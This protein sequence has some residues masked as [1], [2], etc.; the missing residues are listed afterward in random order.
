MSKVNNEVNWQRI[1][2]ICSECGVETWQE[3]NVD[4][5]VLKV[6]HLVCDDCYVKLHPEE[7]L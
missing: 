2:F 7:D 5:F 1:R 6:E 4:I 3:F